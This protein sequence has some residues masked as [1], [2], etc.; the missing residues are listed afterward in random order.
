M[1]QYPELD[2]I[3][4]SIG[5]ISIHWYAISYLVGIGLAWWV[6]KIRARRYDLPFNA[7]QISDLVFYATLGVLLGGRVGYILFYGMG[8]VIENPLSIFQVWKGGMSFH[9]GMLGVLLAMYFF[10][11]KLGRG[12]FE[13]T[14]F[15]APVIPL[16]LGSGRIGNFINSELPGR[17]TDV[18][19]AVVYPNDV[20]GRHPSSLYQAM[21]EGP[22][23]FLLLWWFASRRPARPTMAVSGMFCVGYGALRVLSECFREPDAHLSF[24]AFDFLT[25]GQLLSFPL[26]LFG[27][28]LLV[29]ARR[30]QT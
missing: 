10:A 24:V 18:P 19:W 22:V 27:V 17:V 21:L 20:V 1:W 2:P 13:V 6:I 8:G 7:E 5:P 30:E 25:M 3:A 14:D 11:R 29:L 23:L 12:Y 28:A 15:I 26:V 9:G 4:V 16:G